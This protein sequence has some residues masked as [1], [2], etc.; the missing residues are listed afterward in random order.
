[1]EQ[2]GKR[3]GENVKIATYMTRSVLQHWKTFM[4]GVAAANPCEERIEI[5]FRCDEGWNYYFLWDGTEVWYVSG[6]ACD[7]VFRDKYDIATAQD[8]VEYELNKPAH[9]THILL[10]TNHAKYLS[11]YRTCAGTGMVRTRLATLI[12]ST[13]SFPF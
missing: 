12:E 10:Y 13:P 1:M 3:Y 2:Y 9:I 8:I 4:E 7:A 11:M 5:H 6:E